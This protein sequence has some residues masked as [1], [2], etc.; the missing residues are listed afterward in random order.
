MLP[1]FEERG[2]AGGV[3]LLLVHGWPQDGSCWRLVTPRL[4]EHRCI[5][6]DLRGFGGSAAPSGGYEKERLA[7][8]LL[9]LL[10]ALELERV[11]YVGHDWGAFAGMLLALR[12]PER[13]TG[14]LALSVPHLW[15]SRHDRLNPW[16]LA[17]LAYQVPLATPLLGR[18]LMR[19]GVVRRALPFGVRAGAAPGR[20]TEEM[21]RTFLLREA[22][23]LATGRYADARLTVPTRL[24]VGDDDPIVRGADLRGYEPH[25]DD[26]TVERVP[27]A[28][29]FLPEER[30]GL[31]AARIREQFEAGR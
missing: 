29:H 16:R 28:G 11:G 5:V 14:L 17:A 3:P 10:D 12:A 20:I 26:M 19:A 1:H 15:P 6:A 22:P 7:G 21:Y 18:T 31:V 4:R 25:A 24:V 30:P 13:L 8:D 23:A 27:G 2:P 9:E